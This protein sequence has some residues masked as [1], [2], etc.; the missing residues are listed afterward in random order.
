MSSK[1][2]DKHTVDEF[3][4]AREPKPSKEKRNESS[5]AI[6]RTRRRRFHKR[7]VGEIIAVPRLLREIK[8]PISAIKIK[9]YFA[10]KPSN[11]SQVRKKYASYIKSAENVFQVLNLGNGKQ[12]LDAYDG[13]IDILAECDRK[14]ILEAF[15]SALDYHVSD[16]D[17]EISQS[18]EKNW[19]ILINAMSCAIEIEPHEKMTLI[20]SLCDPR[21]KISRLIKLTLIDVIGDLDIDSDLAKVMLEI[22]LSNRELDDVIRNYAQEALDE[23]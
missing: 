4:S 7:T 11:R 17:L 1:I 12:Y 13:A 3:M 5:L 14:V 21:N 10:L 19:E 6:I 9:N 2:I 16:T 8:S 15:N 20:L 23:L 22:F 18:W